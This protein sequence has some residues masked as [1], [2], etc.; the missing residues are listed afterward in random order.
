L[1]LQEECLRKFAFAA[2]LEGAEVFI[3]GPV[4]S[5]GFGLAPEFQFV[6]VFGCDFAFFE[7]IKKMLAKGGWKIRPLNLGIVL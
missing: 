3:P 4:G 6:K 7:A 5:L 2:K 1:S